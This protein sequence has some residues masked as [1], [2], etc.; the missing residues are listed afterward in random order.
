LNPIPQKL[1][2]IAAKYNVTVKRDMINDSHN[3]GSSAGKETFLG[4]FDDPDIEVVAFFHELGHA[5]SDE[6]VCKR[7]RV[8]SKISGEGLAWELGLG[9]AYEHGYEWDYHSKEMVWARQQLGT[10]VNNKEWTRELTNEGD[11]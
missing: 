8:M 5:L 3:R 6:M 11:T 2:D 1:L 10:Y 4:P 7:G 9:I